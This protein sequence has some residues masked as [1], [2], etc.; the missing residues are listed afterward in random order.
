VEAWANY[1]QRKGESQRQLRRFKIVAVRIPFDVASPSWKPFD[2]VTLGLNSVDLVSVVGE[3]PH[4][5]TK[6]RLQRFARLPGGQM[7]TAAATCARLGLR[8]RYIGSFGDDVLGQLSR[9]SLLDEGVDLTAAR[10]IAGAA[11]QFAVIIVDARSGERTV[12]WDRDPLLALDP[13]VLP[14]DAILSGR[15]LIV[16]CN[17][18]AAAA[19]AARIARAAGVPTVA[20]IERVRPGINE[21]LQ[22]VDA[23]IMAE[24]FPA[25]LTGYEDQGRAL[26]HIA[27]EFNAP[28]V[29]VTL[30]PDGSLAWCQGREIRTPGFPVD[31]V[32]STGAGDAFRGAFAAA[33]LRHPHDDIEHMLT[34][35]NAVAALNCRA[36]G[37]RGGLPTADEVDELLN[38]PA[39]HRI[40]TPLY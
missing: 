30:G 2:V 37:A 4:A 22:H 5:G 15:M 8:A 39:T 32:D 31:C 3:F 28:L 29:C 6:Q 19:Q 21:L 14:A 33:C 9:Q 18:T 13:A 10:T 25:A 7:A 38:G 12:L 11:N 40:R 24:T 20:D 26:A 1:T 23:M 16:D 27:R 36:L 17:Q 34:F 35:A